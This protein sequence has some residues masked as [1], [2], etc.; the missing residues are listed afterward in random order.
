MGSYPMDEDENCTFIVA[1]FDAKEN[2]NEPAKTTDMR[3]TVLAF[4]DECQ[5]MGIPAHMEVSRSGFGLHVWVFFE[6]PLPARDA[7][8]MFA[9]VLTAATNAAIG[10]DFKYYDRFL[11]AQDTLPMTGSRLGNL[12]A[13]PL[14]G[15]ALE[16]RPESRAG[17]AGTQAKVLLASDSDSG[18]GHTHWSEIRGM[19]EASRLETGV[20]RRSLAIFGVLAQ[21]EAA[22]HGVPVDDVAFHEVGAIDSIVDI[23]GA[24]AGLEALAPDTITAGPIELGGGTVHCNHGELPVPAPATLRLVTG[25]PVRT[26]GFNKEMTTPTGAAILRA[27]VDEF[28]ETAAFTELKT[29]YGIGE[30]KLEKPNVL[31]VSLRESCAPETSPEAGGWQTRRLFVLEA[32]IDDMTG[33]DLGFLMEMLFQA[34]AL[35]V[36]FIPCVM[37]KSRPGQRISVLVPPEKREAVRRCLFIHSSTGGFRE[38]PVDRLELPRSFGTTEDGMRTKTLILDGNPLRS[39]IEFEDRA[40]S[41]RRSGSPLKR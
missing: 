15:W 35:D 10:V 9:A 3:K 22:V 39:K 28:I 32:D 2:A 30:R 12:V 7:R 23:V 27:S 34:G 14:Q 38:Q 20:K 11:P 8:R 17:I 1:D 25:M 41:A 4:Y 37:K 6:K 31:R 21:A 36:V 18:H 13:L 16:F 24:A 40:E 19:L 26:G 33:E 5:K 29:A